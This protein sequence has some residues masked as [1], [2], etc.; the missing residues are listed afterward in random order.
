MIYKIL[1][2]GAAPTDSE[3]KLECADGTEAK[4]WNGCVNN[5][6]K[7]YR[8]PYPYIPCNDL[9][10]NGEFYCMKTCSSNGGK[11]TCTGGKY[12]YCLYLKRLLTKLF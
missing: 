9:N 2:C 1:D 4:K 3:D 10:S 5:G 11:R 12:I 6:S 7:R 8:C